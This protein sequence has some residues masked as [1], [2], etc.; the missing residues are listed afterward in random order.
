MKFYSG[1]CWK[2]RDNI[3]NLILSSIETPN[4]AV[5]RSA[6]NCFPLL[7]F[8]GSGGESGKRHSKNWLLLFKRIIK[9]CYYKI[10]CLVEGLK[11]ESRDNKIEKTNDIELIEFK[12]TPVN[13]GN[14]LD[15]LT[16]LSQQVENL[17]LIIQVFLSDKTPFKVEIPVAYVIQL[18]SY[19]SDI[20]DVKVQY[21]HINKEDIYSLY[22]PLIQAMCSCLSVCIF[23]FTTLL[24]PYHDVIMGMLVKYLSFDDLA[25]TCSYKLISDVLSTWRGMSRDTYYIEK[26]IYFI[27]EEIDISKLQSTGKISNIEENNN[28]NTKKQGSAV[29]RLSPENEIHIS[30]RKEQKMY[31]GLQL[32]K[33]IIEICGVNLPILLLNQSISKVI[34]LLAS[35]YG[36][37]N[38]TGAKFSLNICKI[39]FEI[40]FELMNLHKLGFPSV[41]SIFLKFFVIGSEDDREVIASYCRDCLLKSDVM[42]HPV[43]P[44]FQSSKDISTRVDGLDY[45]QVFI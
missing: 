17:I 39:L 9:S 23:Q 33:T 2:F 7:S 40:S 3:Q 41:I 26:F 37:T 38:N 34:F 43:N 44:V 16:L 11:D 27:L 12:T 15:Y 1:P 42:L 5:R 18:F 24:I 13:N 21:S 30:T 31:D 4:G 25:M 19:A 32:L 22:I 45:S 14:L 6:I 8:C 20:L 36:E 10:Q 35:I 28:K 29:I